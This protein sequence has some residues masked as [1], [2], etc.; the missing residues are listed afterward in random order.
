MSELYDIAPGSQWNRIYNL[1][2]DPAVSEVEV[3][4]P[5][6][7]FIKKSGKR[8]HVED[9]FWTSEKDYLDSIKPDVLP[10]LTGVDTEDY[11]PAGSI[12]EG[13]L[14]FSRGGIDVQA[15]CH[16]M[17]PPVCDYPQ[18]TLA[19]RSKSLN[20]VDSLAA[21]GSMSTEM[22]QFLDMAVSA[23]LTVVF[24]GQSGAGKDLSGETLIPTPSG[25][26]AMKDVLIGD[27]VFNEKG[28]AVE[29]LNKYEPDLDKKYLVHFSNGDSVKA[30]EGHLW[31][32]VDL[33]DGAFQESLYNVRLH[34]NDYSIS[35]LEIALLGNDEYVNVDDFLKEISYVSPVKA[36]GVNYQY[37]AVVEQLE[38]IAINAGDLYAVTTRSL[39]DTNKPLFS[40]QDSRY[41]EVEKSLRA[42]DREEISF[43]ELKAISKDE[44]IFNELTPVA[45]ITESRVVNKKEAAQLLLTQYAK[46]KA[47]RDAVD[48]ENKSKT[49]ELYQNMTT[50]RMFEAMYKNPVANQGEIFSKKVAR[51]DDKEIVDIENH[52]NVLFAVERLHGSVEYAPH[53]NSSMPA[54]LV[55]LWLG[56]VNGNDGRVITENTEERLSQI[57][58]KLV[59][60]GVLESRIKI[61]LKTQGTRR[62]DDIYSLRVGGFKQFVKSNF[63][64]RSSNSF[65]KR[66]P[67]SYI[68]E[69]T[70]EREQLVAGIIEGGGKVS[71]DG[72]GSCSFVSTNEELVGDLRTV[73]SSLGLR[74]SPIRKAKRTISKD[75]ESIEISAGLSINF[76]FNRNVFGLNENIVAMEERLANLKKL[77]GQVEHSKVYITKIEEYTPKEDEK[78]YCIEVDTPSHLFLAGETFVPTHNTTMLE[79]LTK[80]VPDHYRIGVA[81]DTPELNLKQSNVTYLH[82]VPWAPGMLE[83][84]VATLQ[85]V[86]SQFQRNRCD[87]LI[88]GETRGKE[89]GDFLIAANSGMEG[90]MTTI[91]AND[92]KQCLVKMTNFAMKAA[93]KQP[94]RAINNDIAQAVDIV[95]QLVV[96][97]GK[98]RVS[99]I[100]EIIPVL[101]DTD[102]AK[103][104]TSDIYLWDRPADKFYKAANMSDGLRNTLNERSVRYEDFLH[105]SIGNRVNHHKFDQNQSRDFG[106]SSTITEQKRHP[107]DGTKQE[108]RASREIGSRGVEKVGEDAKKKRG[109]PTFKGRKI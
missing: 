96:I 98:H 85:W 61:V 43:N 87:K 24:S 108:V 31:R 107:S 77:G 41:A 3:N 22:K 70:S 86:V 9:I 55:G 54:Y 82:S 97:D 91:H 73:V 2:L 65:I 105:T 60:L 89:F 23:N 36:N 90:S 106:S 27:Y 20:T 66:I 67:D 48:F 33:N 6:G 45:G 25:F 59:S 49:P 15:R 83:T 17:L 50:K 26:R 104:T 40:M 7:V 64:K 5:T 88:I 37:D 79:A 68:Y 34:L 99:H 100:T 4:T 81:E 19:K 30:G 102:E 14:M 93:D 46:N 63:Q 44:D 56:S 39:L 10:L 58:A 12:F 101:G 51:D 94:I 62:E 53:E 71:D 1:M 84:D 32:V 80:N 69:T 42:W 8:I 103:I 35:R 38:S 47:V 92:P 28:K 109:L 57:K 13:R 16:I 11:S 72:K 75:G 18:V 52:E 78:F 95:V 29:V 74:T 21:M 76:F